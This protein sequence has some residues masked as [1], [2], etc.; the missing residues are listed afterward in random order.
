MLAITPIEDMREL[1]DEDIFEWVCELW[2]ELLSK[3]EYHRYDESALEAD[4]EFQSYSTE[5]NT[6]KTI[7]LERMAAWMPEQT[8]DN[9]ESRSRNDD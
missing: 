1:A 5:Y 9:D 8:T 3:I 4:G 6:A 7:V 2:H